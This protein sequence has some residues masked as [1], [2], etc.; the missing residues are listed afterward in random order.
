[1][2]LDAPAVLHLKQSLS[3]LRSLEEVSLLM[4]GHR[5]ETTAVIYMMIQEHMSQIRHLRL[6]LS[7][8]SLGEWDSVPHFHPFTMPN[9]R[10]LHL[11]RPEMDVPVVRAFFEGLCASQLETLAIANWGTPS[12][13]EASQLRL[14]E[15]LRLGVGRM[16][17]TY[18]R[19]HTHMPIGDYFPNV[20]Y[21]TLDGGV[22]CF[23]K[24]RN[25][26]ITLPAG[27]IELRLHGTEQEMITRVETSSLARSAEDSQ[28]RHVKRI[29]IYSLGDL[30]LQWGQRTQQTWLAHDNSRHFG[31][32]TTSPIEGHFCPA[33]R[34]FAGGSGKPQIGRIKDRRTLSM[35]SLR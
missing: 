30:V 11:W 34:N 20:R 26:R 31:A 17:V 28:I 33:R 21:L 2:D 4:R 8:R 19:N 1:M 35:G 6:A 9:L 12:E 25:L 29:I 32:G 14:P 23:P 13:I 15:S 3:H 16:Y 22:G 18:S 5:P 27:L 24:D 10:S 7:V